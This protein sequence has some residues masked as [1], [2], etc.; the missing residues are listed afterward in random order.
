MSNLNFFQ[1]IVTIRGFR[2]P[3]IKRTNVPKY[4]PTWSPAPVSS[5]SFS[6]QTPLAMSE[7][8]CSSDTITDIVL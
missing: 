6:V 4:W 3:K 1:Q 7:D 2:A 8:C 5:L